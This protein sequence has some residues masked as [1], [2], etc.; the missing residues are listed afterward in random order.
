MVHTEDGPVLAKAVEELTALGRTSLEY[1]PDSRPVLGEAVA[2]QRAVA[3]SEQTGAP[4]Y[5]VHVSS[6]RALRVAQEAQGRGVPV[7]VET[8][9]IY[10]HF[11]RERFEGSDR[12]LYVGQPPLREQ[13]DQN[14]LWDGLA[15][16]SVH[17]V[18]TDHV[19][20][21]RETKM[22]PSQTIAR[23]R[24]GLNNHTAPVSGSVA[25]PC[26]LRWPQLQISGR[27]VGWPTKG[28]SLGTRPS[29]C[30]RTIVPMWFV[31]S[32]AG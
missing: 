20:Y 5:A 1:F 10:L 30:R 22:D 15:N 19:A 26:M 3:M 32:C 6:E 16:G 29:S 21:T 7:Y 28:L 13:R 11:T 18:G 4:I 8:R 24:A 14:A 2:M 31:R 12:G 9:P 23:H 17:V 25:R 27:A